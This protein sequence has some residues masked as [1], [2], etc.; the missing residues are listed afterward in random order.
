MKSKALSIHSTTAY[1]ASIPELAYLL[2]N[3]PT[4]FL[5]LAAKELAKIST[6][7][8]PLPKWL[9]ILAE[10][11]LPNFAL[12]IRKAQ[13]VLK[14]KGYNFSLPVYLCPK[15]QEGT[16]VTLSREVTGYHWKFFNSSNEPI[17]HCPHCGI[18]Y[19]AQFVLK[20]ISEE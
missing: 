12:T 19:E 8:H 15:C 5:L 14:H 3:R 16:K 11:K 7:E 6:E 1:L 4:P 10:G 2:E 9:L 20:G 18:Q 17:T 13:A